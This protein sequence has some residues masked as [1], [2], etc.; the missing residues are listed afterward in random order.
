MQTVGVQFFELR[1]FVAQ[2]SFGEHFACNAEIIG[3]E[4]G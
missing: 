4:V 3:K 2:G 1:V